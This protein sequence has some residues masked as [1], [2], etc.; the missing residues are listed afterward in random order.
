MYFNVETIVRGNHAYKSMWVAVAEEL[1]CQREQ[2]N[3]KDSFAVA[4]MT[5]ELIIGS[6]KF[7]QLA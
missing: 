2:V 1:P 3:S 6:E 4:V 7:P 5:G